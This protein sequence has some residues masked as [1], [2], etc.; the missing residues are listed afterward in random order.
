MNELH[1]ST[2]KMQIGSK[3]KSENDEEIWFWGKVYGTEYDYYI[4]MGVNFKDNYEFP[5]KRFYY[6]NSLNYKFALLPETYEYHDKDYKLNYLNPLLGKPETII[7]PYK[8]DVDPDAAV[9]S[10]PVDI[11]VDNKADLDESIDAVVVVKLDKENFTEALKLSYI[12]RQ[13]DY[14]TN[15]VPQGAFKLI[16][17]HEMRRDDSWNGLKSPELTDLSK[18]H[19]FRP[20]TNPKNKERVEL[21]EAIFLPDLLD[22]IADDTTYG[23]WSVQLD[24]T[25]KIVLF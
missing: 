22:S 19:H 7:V 24:P 8:I 11:P 4:A 20:I 2:D 18:Y 13:I 10:P 9:D 23:S 3:L 5:E 6:S 12:V 25:K 15:V 16:S 1:K 21:D 14:E 17:I